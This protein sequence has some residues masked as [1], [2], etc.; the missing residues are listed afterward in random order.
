MP[1]AVA[2]HLLATARGPFWHFHT[3]Q[4]GVAMELHQRNGVNRVI[5]E[6]GANCESL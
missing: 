3:A 4:A 5:H 2:A 6:V 1:L